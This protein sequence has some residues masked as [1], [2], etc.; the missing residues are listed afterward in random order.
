M[1]P[2]PL[3]LPSRAGFLRSG[4]TASDRNVTESVPVSYTAEKTQGTGRKELLFPARILRK[5]IDV[6]IIRAARKGRFVRPPVNIDL[7]R[8]DADIRRNIFF[9]VDRK[10]GA[11]RNLA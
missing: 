11:V 6:R 4:F 2:I 8:S 10:T 3:P 7:I 9:S 5:Q 1:D